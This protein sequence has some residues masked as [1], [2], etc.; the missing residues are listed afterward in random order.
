VTEFTGGVTTGFTGNRAPYE[1]T[2]GPDGH[3][4][5]TENANPGALGRVNSDGTV[6]EFTGGVTTGFT[7]SRAP[8]GITTGP[9]GHI[10]FTENASPG[11]LGRI[12]TGPGV[13]T[14][15]ASGVGPG[16]AT[17]N[18]SV[19]PNGQLTVYSFEYGPTSAYGS[20]T[21]VAFAG[22]SVAPVAVSAALSGL[23]PNTPY[24]YRLTATNP[25][26]TTAG[27]DRTF[28]TAAAPP[29]GGG[30][31][32][33]GAVVA[34]IGTET[35]FPTA[36]PAAPSGPSALTAKRRY[37]TKVSYTL[38]EAASVRFT[39]VQPQP[40]RK[41]K[42]GACVR[43]TTKNRRGHKCT[44]LVTMPGSFTR[45]GNA[46]TNSFRFTGRLAGR[47]LRSGN[48]QLVATPSAAGKPGRATSASFRI[49][50]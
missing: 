20:Q 32:G 9:D 44:R 47:K 16:A 30:G 21:M 41:S 7:A 11:A 36:F 26:D 48:Y 5:F 45:A 33:G 24:H 12:T 35:L 31:G 13:M 37:G 38:N 6:T 42:R 40:G 22:S 8:F 27:A 4:W 39:V 17:L 43:P 46:G 34:A 14:G 3:I 25:S 19:Q 23:A 29:S 49:V 2:T 28:T 15:A 50:K 1:I 18:G 10:W